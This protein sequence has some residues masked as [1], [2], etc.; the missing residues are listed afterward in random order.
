MSVELEVINIGNLP[1]DG[2]GDPLR[3]AFSKINNNFAKL[4]STAWN[5]TEAITVGNIA[6]QVIFTTQANAFTQGTFVVKTYNPANNDFQ[7]I[8][9]S[10]T[11]NNDNSNLKFTGYGT[12]FNGNSLTRYNC[13]V[14][15]GNVNI[16]VSP[17]PNVVLNHFINYQVTDVNDLGVGMLLLAEGISGDPYL[18]TESGLGITTES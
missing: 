6:N 10:I 5:I 14:A 4:S 12:T 2:E 13:T 8:T 15:S 1:N 11:T 7:N 9:L 18:I 17:I 3:V 16:L